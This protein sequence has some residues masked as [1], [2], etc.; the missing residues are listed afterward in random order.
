MCLLPLYMYLKRLPQHTH[1]YTRTHACSYIY[2]YIYTHVCTH[3]HTQAHTRKHISRNP[4]VLYL[5][6]FQNLLKNYRYCLIHYAKGS[7]RKNG[8]AILSNAVRELQ[9]QLNRINRTN[10]T[11]IHWGSKPNWISRGRLCEFMKI[12]I[13]IKIIVD[14]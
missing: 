3:A 6:V 5:K 2:I 8:C 11:K 12:I 14:I 9:I 4:E 7:I 10:C 1:T 13:I